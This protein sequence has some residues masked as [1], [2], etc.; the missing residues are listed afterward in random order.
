MHIYHIEVFQMKFSERWSP[1]K[2][3]KKKY[4]FN[5]PKLQTNVFN[6]R[7]FGTWWGGGAN[8]R[9]LPPIEAH[10]P[11]ATKVISWRPTTGGGGIVWGKQVR[12]GG[13]DSDKGEMFSTDEIFSN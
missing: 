11:P 13:W 3:K 9:M 12:G 10:W 5:F 7:P 2:E 4:D 6:T 8:Q 1:S